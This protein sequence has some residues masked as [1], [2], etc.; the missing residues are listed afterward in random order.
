ML[1]WQAQTKVNTLNDDQTKKYA[2]IFSPRL[3]DS[4]ISM[5][6]ANNLQQQG[7]DITIFSDFINQLKDWFPGFTIYPAS[8]AT[9]DTLKQYDVLICEFPHDLKQECWDLKPVICLHNDQYFRRGLHM[10]EIQTTACRELF[11]IEQPTLETGITL[12]TGVEHRK[13]K[14]RI[15]IHALAS[16]PHREWLLRHYI[17]FAKYWQAQGFECHFIAA[18]KERVRMQAALDAGLSV[19]IF[20]SLSETTQFIAESGY[21]L[22]NF[23]GIAHLTSSLKIPTLALAMRAGEYRLWRPFWGLGIVLMP[24][25]LLVSRQLKEKFWKYVI[26]LRKVNK[27]FKQLILNDET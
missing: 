18:P 17:K 14:K 5:V 26:S 23:S 21:F 12:P 8:A 22:G 1:C 11:K 13:Y 2:F 15:I 4:V 25:S 7:Y 24:S 9:L 6:L 20:A 10:A 3:G 19:P 16:E 27:N